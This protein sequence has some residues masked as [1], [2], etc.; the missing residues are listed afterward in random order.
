METRTGLL[1]AHALAAA[2]VVVFALSAIRSGQLVPLVFRLLIAGL[3][4]ALGVL[5]YRVRGRQ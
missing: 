3:L 1:V 2:V 4:L 5:L